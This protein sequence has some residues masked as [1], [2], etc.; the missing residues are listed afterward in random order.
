[1]NVAIPADKQK[2]ETG[3][4]DIIRRAIILHGMPDKESYYDPA[5][6]SQSNSHWLPWLQQQLIVHDIVAQTPEMPQPYAPIY[7]EWLEEFERYSP[8][9]ADLLV[10][11]SLG[12]GFL[13]RWLAE[14]GERIPAKLVL[15][16]P[17]I[18]VE[19]EYRPFFDFVLPHTIASLTKK[20]VD[21]LGSTDDSEEIK[22]SIAYIRARAEQV[23]Y[24]EFTGYGH[25]TLGSMKRRDFPELLEICLAR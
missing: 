16:A 10:G 3:V 24:H 6:D 9:K 25:F 19:K 1:M 4:D 7:E 22:H 20:G 23:R 2:I 17:W 14:K 13:L 15:V 5:R 12:G 11:H 21:M 18:D 8:E